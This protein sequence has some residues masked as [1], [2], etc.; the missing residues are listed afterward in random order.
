[1]LSRN[2][3]HKLKTP[4]KEKSKHFAPVDGENSP[5]KIL[6]LTVRKLE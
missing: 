6:N 4:Q 2:F 5:Q 3:G 1:M